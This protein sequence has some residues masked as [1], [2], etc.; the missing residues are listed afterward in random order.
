VAPF[1]IA[2]AATGDGRALPIYGHHRIA[3]PDFSG[4]LM[5]QVAEQPKLP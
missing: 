4:T 3:L 2:S 5:L 1:A